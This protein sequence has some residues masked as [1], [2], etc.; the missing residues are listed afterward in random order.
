[1]T[2]AAGTVSTLLPGFHFICP[3]GCVTTRT[4]FQNFS[5]YSEIEPFP[6]IELQDSTVPR[7]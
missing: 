4:P 5:Y 6:S 3:D 2:L 7:S 1:L